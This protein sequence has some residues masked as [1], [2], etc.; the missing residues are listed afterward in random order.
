MSLTADLLTTV[1]TA[2]PDQAWSQVA[3]HLWARFQAP[4]EGAVDTEVVRRDRSITE[5]DNI[6]SGS[7]WDL[8][9]AFEASVPRASQALVEFWGRVQGGKAVL[10]LDGLSLREAPWLLEQAQGRGYTIHQS[11]AQGSE[12][13]A[14]T[15]AF[16]HALGFP[17]RSALENN[18]ASG[19]HKLAGAV[20]ETSELNF[21]DCVGM[22]GTQPDLVFWHHWPD[23]QLHHLSKPGDGLGKLA[24]AIQAR[25]TSDE[26]WSFVERLAT[27]RRLVITGDH[28][29]AAT[30]LF[31]D[32]A[33]KDQADHMKE[34]FKGQR[35]ADGATTD[36]PWVPP[37]EHSLTTTHGPHRYVL[38]RRKWKSPS[39]YPTLQ[40]G[41]LSL[42]EVFVPFIE[43][44]K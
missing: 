28:G 43:M 41:G 2:P 7:G 44:S 21:A 22:V 40:H 42:L 23:E 17:Q 34:V 20:T 10:I 33:A 16:A 12:L 26:F 8:W 35:S 32:L 30:G 3:D 37:V 19:T 24:K 38:G 15:T 1:L 31:P 9:D 14:E 11:C 36:A 18:G 29:Y 39:G 27:G 5:L 13:P 25:L 6:L 4:I